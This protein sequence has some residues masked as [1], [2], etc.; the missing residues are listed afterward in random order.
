MRVPRD[1]VPFVLAEAADRLVS[2]EPPLAS[3]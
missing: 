2:F 3:P 1:L